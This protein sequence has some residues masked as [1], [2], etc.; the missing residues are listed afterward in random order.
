MEY[1]VSFKLDFRRNIYPGKFIV[2]EGIDG[3]GKTTQ[4]HII[5]QHLREQGKDVVFTKE[6]TDGPIG[7]FIRQTLSGAV[8][9]PAVA[10]QHLLSADR[11][12]HEE[13]IKKHLESSKTVISDRYLW[14]SVAYG[15]ADWEN[16]DYTNGKVLLVAQSILSMY[17]QF[18]LPNVTIYLK[19]S[20]DTAL[21]RIEQM[22]KE[23]EMYENRDK[24]EKIFKG[25]EW[26]VSQ[27][28][29]EITVVDGEKD[30]T[31]VTQDILGKLAE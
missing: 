15:M 20:I 16:T 31:A 30:V 29:S 4:V 9:I 19:V 3:S 13:E 14:S 10:L 22:G 7:K 17:H 28:P 26:L 12:V 27:F 6:P 8:R 24:L 18:I 23:K 2:L 25:Y 5:A 11:A 1:T 21:L